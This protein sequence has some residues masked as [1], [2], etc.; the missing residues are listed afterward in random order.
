MRTSTRRKLRPTISL[1]DVPSLRAH[2]AA[3]TSRAW[4]PRSI[5]SHP[6]VA[7]SA[8]PFH[9][10][11]NPLLPPER[12]ALCESGLATGGL[13]QDLRAAG[14]DDDG[15]CVREDGRDGEAAGALDVHEEGARAGDERLGVML[16]AVQRSIPVVESPYLQLV[17]ASLSLRGRV[18]EI[19]CENLR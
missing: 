14:A 17:L 15:L 4:L 7:T 5:S 11:R 1:D 8:L 18:Q 2:T 16:D 12:A 6:V 10:L 9:T 3:Q 13:A 19:D